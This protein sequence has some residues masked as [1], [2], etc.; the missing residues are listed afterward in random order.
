[1]NTDNKKDSAVETITTFKGFDKDLR[2][3]D[4]QFE[5][6]KTYAHEG[7][8]KACA[9]GFHACEFP[10]DVFRYYSPTV[11]RFAVVEQSG[12]LSRHE[13]DS[14]VASRSITVKAEIGIPELVK[15]SI[16][17]VWKRAEVA[18]D[19]KASQCASG[20]GSN[21]AASGNYSNLAASGYGSNLAASGYGSNLAASGDG[22][23]LAA[24]GYG[25]N[26]AAS[27]YGSNLAAS[28]KDSTIACA[29]SDCRFKAA[30]GG[31]I[32]AAYHDGK[33]TR[34]AVAYV[35]EGIKADTW[36]RLSDAGEFVEC[37]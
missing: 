19:D 15:A 35:G 36:Y 14:K 4:Y 2:C 23:K 1:M 12:D 7:E 8:V 24:S 9:G 31:A 34:F 30:E 28:G 6:G 3:R 33:R 25:S 37:E 17:W 27:G 11:S 13:M 10:L 18:A 5:I 32:A 21:L 22:S 20:Y 16:E 26:L 29:A